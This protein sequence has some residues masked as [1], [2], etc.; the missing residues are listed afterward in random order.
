DIYGYCSILLLLLVLVLEGVRWI[1]FHKKRKKNLLDTG[2]SMTIGNRE[3]QEDQAEFLT[4][5]AGTMA[6]LADGG[7]QI[8]GGRIAAQTAVQTCV[9]IFK[10]YNA[11]NNPQY[12]FRKAFNSAN[13][14][15]LKCLGDEGRGTASVGCVLIHQQVLYYAVV[16]NVKIGV[17]REGNLV[18]VSTGHT[19]SVLAEKQFHEGR[20]SREDAL[21]LLE[22]Q[23]LYNY[24][25]QDEFKDIE[26]VDAP[27]QL[28]QGDIVV[29]MSDGVYDLLSLKEIER[30]LE[31]TEDCQKKA[32][33]VTELI[34]R[35]TKPFKDNAS[36]VLLGI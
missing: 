31:G 16:G 33:N 17:Y 34:N 12:F 3:V 18:P 20:I 10:D 7:G 35:S 5:S 25:G 32:F 29:L 6:V 8:Y 9:E 28:K 21:V 11:F 4:T 24:L 27:V 23:R 26:Y 1:F 22:N 15:I 14:E 30:V 2:K 19:I 13:R 36:I